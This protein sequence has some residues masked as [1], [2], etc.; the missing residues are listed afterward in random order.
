[1]KRQKSTALPKGSSNI[2]TLNYKNCRK[3]KDHCHYTG[4]YRGAAHSV[5]NLIYNIPKEIPVIFHNR[6][7]YPYCFI[8]RKLAKEFQG[9]F[10]F[11]GEN[12]E[13]HKIFSASIAKE[14]KK[15]DKNEKEIT[16]TI[17]YKLQF[18]HSAKFVASS[19]S[20]IVDNLAERI[21]KSNCKY[22]QENKN[23]ETFFN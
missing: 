4:K 9:E 10:Y 8:I 13:K 18:I 21:H 6:S 19:L 1:M 11:L 5:C 23:C 14:I 12:T 3:V 2:N 15:I 7:N 17:S 16:K 20:N 22:G